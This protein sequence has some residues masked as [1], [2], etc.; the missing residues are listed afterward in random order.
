MAEESTQSPGDET[1]RAALVVAVSRYSDPTLRQLRAPAADAAAL[2]TVLG[3]PELGDFSVTTVVDG[4]AHE[5]RIAVE[6]FLSGQRPGDLSLVYL[7]CHGLMDARRRLYFAATDTLKDRLAATGIEAR[8]LLDQLE[9][10]RARRQVIILD[11][12]FSG[13]FAFGSKGD[14][15]LRLGDRFLGQGRGRVVLT[16]SRATEYSFEGSPTSHSAMPGSVF[17]S[18]L[19]TGIRTGA[20]DSDN[21]GWITV[22]DA[23][24]YAFG[25]MRAAGAQ[26]TPQRW[27]YGAEGG[28][29]LARNPTAERGSGPIPRT[30]PTDQASANQ[31]DDQDDGHDDRVA[32]T[33]VGPTQSTFRQY[34][35]LAAV[36]GALAVAA[37]A[38]VSAYNVFSSRAPGFSLTGKV[39]EASGPWRLHV[40]SDVTSPNGCTVTITDLDHDTSRTVPRDPAYNTSTWQMQ[41]TGRFR[42]EPSQTRCEIDAEDGAGDALLPLNVM[43][44][45]SEAFNP[46]GTVTVHV[47]EGGFTG[48]ARSCLLVL[49]DGATGTTVATTSV[50]PQRPTQQMDA[51]SRSSVYLSNVPCSVTVSDS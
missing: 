29:V 13:A 37:I 24:A 44:G 36:A 22:D 27:L 49:R 40:S 46:S 32:L 23:Y 21:D 9:E 4:S 48:G 3:D 17:T 28:I 7:S 34:W 2:G 20:A 30:G 38:G 8:W 15:D 31:H 45:D 6:E 19:A 47:D 5:I 16:A 25:E 33:E 1:R 51:G 42:L 43:R 14:D 12:C 39:V 35:R 18:A 50:T 11:C 26:Q 41:A 10:C